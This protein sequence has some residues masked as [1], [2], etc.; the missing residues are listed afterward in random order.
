[1]RA[2]RRYGVWCRRQQLNILLRVLSGNT[3][4]IGLLFSDSVLIS[5]ATKGS[6]CTRETHEALPA[7]QVELQC[8]QRDPGLQD[9][10]ELE[11]FAQGEVSYSLFV[12]LL[13]KSFLGTCSVLYKEL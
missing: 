11:T 1:M 4:K 6:L 7:L 2:G 10:K 9:L 8:S 13:M 3:V 5:V 12:L